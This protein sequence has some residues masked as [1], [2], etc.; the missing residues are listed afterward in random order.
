MDL[1][2]LIDGELL[3]NAFPVEIDSTSTVGH[4]KDAIKLK[5]SNFFKDVDA[6]NLTL[7]LV[8]IPEDK[9]GS[10]IKLGELDEKEELTRPRKTM[11]ALFPTPPDELTYILVQRPLLNAPKITLAYEKIEPELLYIAEEASRNHETHSVKQED[12][13][14]YQ[15]KALGNFYKRPL[16]YGMTEKN[17]Y[18]Q[19]LGNMLGKEPMTQDG[20]TLRNIVENDIDIKEF[21]VV[22]IV[23]RSGSG[24]TATVIELAKRHFVIYVMCSDPRSEHTFEVTDPNF[25]QLGKDV[26]NMCIAFTNS[27]QYSG[28]KELDTG[29]KTVAAE[30]IEIEFLA[31]LIFLWI[32]FRKY[33]QLTPE[34]F[35]R[36]QLNGGAK[37]VKRLVEKLLKYDSKTI[38]SMLPCVEEYLSKDYLH[39]RGLA[40]ALDEAHVAMRHILA[41]KLISPQALK[42]NNF[43]DQKGRVRNDA[44]RGFLTPLCAT[45]SRR[46]A[47]LITLGTS[48]TLRDADHVYSAINKK[49]RRC[50]ITHFP[51]FNEQDIQAMLSEVI[52][53]SDCDIPEEKRL[54]LTGRPRFSIRVVEQL[55]TG[56]HH[57]QESKQKLLENALDK[58]IQQSNDDLEDS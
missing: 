34:Q 2:C 9:E 28:L 23:G 40:I 47:T 22:A 15:R 8:K 51:S 20:L 24:K 4:L 26:E 45:L 12:V 49:T 11:T 5:K 55:I 25:V 30:R 58:T 53:I 57:G 21:S 32:L 50:K 42:Y 35:F 31:R 7:W 17:I 13:E 37:T 1:F 33:P 38:D 3:K 52:D 44:R 48:M 10:A 43:L 39:E 46:R 56:N 6:D 14:E 41:G 19:M 16:P 29:L 18:L 36:E 27:G 54:L